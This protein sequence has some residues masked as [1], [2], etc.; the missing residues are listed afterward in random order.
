MIKDATSTALD[1]GGDDTVDT[2]DGA[3]IVVG[4]FGGDTL[5]GGADSDLVVGDNGTAEFTTAG[6]VT[7]IESTDIDDST[8]GADIIVVNDG[9]NQVI[10]GAGMDEITGGAGTD[11]VLGDH[12]SMTFTEAGVL[13][14]MVSS[15]ES[16][17]T[18]DV[19]TLGDGLNVAVAGQGADDLT[20]GADEDIIFGDSGVV[21]FYDDGVIKDA[22]STALDEGGDD[23]VDTGDGANIVVGGFGGDTL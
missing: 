21:N 15:L 8:G 7:L 17:G 2:G 14:Q 13:T 11:Y 20:G 3:N 10:G 18:G 12:G 19:I 1:E 4:G 5:T 23:T 9:A 6:V 16:L 22:T